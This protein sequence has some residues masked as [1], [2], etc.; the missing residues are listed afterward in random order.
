MEPLS[1][2]LQ[3]AR[4]ATAD[5]LTNHHDPVIV[6]HQG[7]LRIVLIALGQIERGGYFATRLHEARPIVIVH[8]TIAP[9]NEQH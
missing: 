4:A 8:P 1:A 5:A 3:R 9:E 6:G 2:A 7:I